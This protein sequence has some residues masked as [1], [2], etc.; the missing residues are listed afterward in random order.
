MRLDTLA[1]VEVNRVVEEHIRRVRAAGRLHAASGREPRPPRALRLRRG[2]DA[3]DAG[4]ARAASPDLCAD[5]EHGVDARR[6]QLVRAELV[7]RHQ[8]DA[9]AQGRGVRPLRDGA[10]RLSASPER[11]GRSGRPRR[12][13]ARAAGASTRSR[14]SSC[15]D[16]SRVT[17]RLG[18]L[19]PAPDR[20]R[21]ARRDGGRLRGDRAA[22]A[23]AEPDHGNARRSRL[24]ARLRV[25]AGRRRDLVRAQAARDRHRRR[26][27]RRRAI[28]A[29]ARP[30]APRAGRPRLVHLGRARRARAASS[31]KARTG[32]AF[33]S[34]G[35]DARSC[36]RIR[37][38]STRRRRRLRSSASSPRVFS[39][40]GDGRRDRITATYTIDERARATML[41]DGQTPRARAS[42]ARARDARR[43]SGCVDGRPV[44]P[45]T[46]EIRLRA[47]DRAGNR[48]ART[49][50]VHGRVSVCRALARARSRWSAGKRFS[51]RVSTDAPS[52]GGSSP[53]EKGS[54]RRQVL[55]LRAP[56]DA[57]HVRAL[58]VGRTPRGP[59]RG[60]RLAQQQ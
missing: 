56:D 18:A 34:S 19:A 14:S 52:Y 7:R 21:A 11:D 5:L 24:L 16:S 41:V 1:H 38:A 58:R 2:R 37:F 3:A 42:S 44:R 55:V 29:H 47:I 30:Q 8:R 27:R 25:R 20:P 4:A 59:G 22:Q 48:S 51:V 46:Y 15:A 31:P 9:R 32:R 10:P 35:T 57:G 60:R 13:T 43:G 12:S 39:P 45:G 54:G 49:R 17:S 33:S 28:R 36:S 26:A 23:R 50:A 53:G 6:G 40:D